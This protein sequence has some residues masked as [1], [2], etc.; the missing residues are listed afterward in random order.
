[1]RVAILAIV[2]VLFGCG[3][4]GNSPLVAKSYPV[5]YHTPVK[6]GSFTPLYD[7][8]TNDNSWAVI[9][10]HSEQLTNSG[11]NLI[12][13]GFKSQPADAS[14]WKNFE[15]SIFGWQNNKLVNQTS[16]WFTAGENIITGTTAAKFADFDNNGRLDFVV[17]PYTDGALSTAT[18]AY[19]YLNNST[20]KFTRHAININISASELIHVDSKN[21]IEAHDIAVSD[22]N[23]DGLKDIVIADYGWNTALIFNQ[24][25]GNFTSYTQQNRNMSGT[26]SLAVADFL[27]NGTKTILAVDQMNQLNRP[28]LYSWNIDNTNNLNFTLLSLGS[29][30]RFEL[31]K[32]SG[33]N[34]GGGAPGTRSHDVRVVAHDWNDNGAMDAII[35]SRPGF[36]NGE[37]P[38]YS[39]IQFLKNNGNGNF[40]DE[41]ENVLV[42]YNTNT[43]VSYNPKLTD[44]NGDGLIDIL[45]PTA[46]DFSGI[47][48]SSQILLKTSDG[49]YV[50]AYQNVLTD[51]SSQ[52]NFIAHHYSLAYNMGNSLNILRSP[53]NKLYLVTA[54]KIGN[55][56]AVYLSLVGDSFVSATQAISTVQAKWPWMSDATANTILSQTSKTYLNGHVIDLEAALNPVGSLQIKHLPVTGYISGIKIDSAQLPVQALDSLG[57]NFAVNISPTVV[58]HSN[59]WSRNSVPDQVTPRSQTEYLIGGSNYEFGGMRFGGNDSIWSI[60]TPLLPVNESLSVS[61]QIT[62]LN[63]NPWIQLNGMWGSINYSSMFESTVT[64]KKDN[65]QNQFGYILT[66]SNINPGLVTRVDNFHAIWLE[67]GYATERFGLFTGVRPWIVNGGVN[68]ELP[69]S[70]DTQGNIQ[71]TNMHY[72]INNPVNMYLRTVYTD[73]ITKNVAYKISGMFVDNGQYRTQLELKYFY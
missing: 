54:V 65:W 6:V 27:N 69:T 31:P 50:A 36:T 25:G 42:G 59:F 8:S 52:S 1:M 7:S 45:L 15:I 17:A 28:A 34:F 48:D 39:E 51:F 13:T 44:I 32:W 53:D 23:N 40:T 20:N 26:S 29:V 55:E 12:V 22:L 19:V 3:T 66:T 70:I 71:Y 35:L 16:S 49:K 2:L 61:A 67:T 64:Y 68:A 21:Y 57:R 63:Y 62:T 56:M 5:P 38:K 37:W 60:G 58:D 24:G 47:N 14:N 9:D 46:G 43:V 10:L 33:Y 73:T 4:G 72:K 18:P 11:D 30:P 41:T